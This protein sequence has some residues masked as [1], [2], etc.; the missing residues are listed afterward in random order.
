MA[1]V[2]KYR[3]R[4][5]ICSSNSSWIQYNLL[6]NRQYVIVSTENWYR[7]LN[8]VFKLIIKPPGWY[9]LKDNTCIFY[10]YLTMVDIWTPNNTKYCVE[11]AWISCSREKCYICTTRNIVILTCCH[12]VCLCLA[13]KLLWKKIWLF[14]S[15]LS[16]HCIGQW[17]SWGFGNFLCWYSKLSHITATFG[18]LNWVFRIFTPMSRSE[19]FLVPDLMNIQG[20]PQQNSGPC[21]ILKHKIDQG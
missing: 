18:W 15:V 7:V 8:Q 2:S 17:L 1:S 19:P 20:V 11:I 5:C 12:P 14:F 9:H 10:K 13:E 21:C 3:N 16:V 6:K 4:F